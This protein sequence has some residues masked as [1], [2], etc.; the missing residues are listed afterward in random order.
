MPAPAPLKPADG[1]NV[2]VTCSTARVSRGDSVDRSS[3][4]NATAPLTTPA[5]MLV[6]E[7]CM[8]AFAPLPAT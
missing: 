4:S 2:L 8:K 6:P 5:D 7:S 1:M 3:S